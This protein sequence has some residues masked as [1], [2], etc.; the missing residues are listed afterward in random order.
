MGDKGGKRLGCIV[1]DV[2][3]Q[4]KELITCEIWQHG[5]WEAGGDWRD[6]GA[7]GVQAEGYFKAKETAFGLVDLLLLVTWLSYVE[8]SQKSQN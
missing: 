7:L 1:K 5:L 2:N 6:V 4:V 8:I 3:C